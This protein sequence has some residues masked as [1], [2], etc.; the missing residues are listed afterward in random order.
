[1]QQQLAVNDLIHINTIFFNH[2]LLTSYNLINKKFIVVRIVV[3][4]THAQMTLQSEIK[5]VRDSQTFRHKQPG[6]HAKGSKVLIYCSSLCKG[7]F[8]D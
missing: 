4:F 1:M 3:E 2:N 6:P 5:S 8:G 7:I